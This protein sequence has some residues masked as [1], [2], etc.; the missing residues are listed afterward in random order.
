MLNFKLFT[1]LNSLKINILCFNVNSMLT[2]CEICMNIFY[3]FGLE[4]KTSLIYN[5]KPKSYD[6]AIGSNDLKT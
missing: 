3:I 1:I 4:I 6:I 5:L 2:Q